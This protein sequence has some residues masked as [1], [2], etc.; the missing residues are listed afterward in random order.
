MTEPSPNEERRRPTPVRETLRGDSGAA[1]DAASEGRSAAGGERTAPA[2]LPARPRTAPGQA[3]GTAAAGGGPADRRGP[4][5][6][7]ESM[8]STPSEPP[9]EEEPS[10]RFCR[11]A[12]EWIARLAGHGRSGTAPDGGAPLMSVAFARAHDPETT[13][14]DTLL[15]GRTLAGVEE[16]ELVEL[17]DRARPFRSAAQRS[18]LFSDTRLRKKEH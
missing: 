1:P 7:R 16:Q 9:A 2:P 18:E 6:V 12:E 8:E 11:G 3:P 4:T 5:P 13:L 14:F 17:L 15:V 10:V